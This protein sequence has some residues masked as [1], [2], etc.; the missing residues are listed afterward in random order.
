M[1]SFLA[2]AL[3]ERSSSK[4]LV[5]TNSNK[6]YFIKAIQHLR[7]S[8]E[9][10]VFRIQ[11]PNAVRAT[12]PVKHLAS[13]RMPSLLC[14]WLITFAL[15]GMQGWISS[16]ASTQEKLHRSSVQMHTCSTGPTIK[17]I[18]RFIMAAEPP[19]SFL[20]PSASND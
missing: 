11:N 17:T 10:M 9:K 13:I 14:V 5:R 8:P 7:H 15:L 1:F 6:A 2:T 19:H 18:V 20:W 4:L 12:F 16:A 3:C